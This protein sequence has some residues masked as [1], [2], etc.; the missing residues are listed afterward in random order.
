MTVSP[1]LPSSDP[2]AANPPSGASP[3]DGNASDEASL[4]PPGAVDPSDQHGEASGLSDD[5]DVSSGSDDVE[6]VA[7]DKVARDASTA[8]DAPGESVVSSVASVAG[9]A[10]GVSLVA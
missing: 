6:A 3:V 2:K 1:E 7:T 9:A 8:D 5:H 10:G 4:A